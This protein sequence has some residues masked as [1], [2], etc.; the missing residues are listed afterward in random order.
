MS[1][2]YLAWNRHLNI[3]MIDIV[4]MSS[5]DWMNTPHGN[6]SNLAV[7]PS[8]LAP[9]TT[10]MTFFERLGNFLI[11]TSAEFLFNY[12]SREQDEYVQKYFGPGYPSVVEMQK[13]LSLILINYHQSLDGIRAFTPAIVPVG[14]LH[15][16]DRNETLPQVRIII[17]QTHRLRRM[18]IQKSEARQLDKYTFVEPAE[19]AR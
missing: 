2:C 16:I 9:Y 14:G 8:I 13:D 12:Y 11:S 1:V 17:S 10:P 6:P 5:T 18:I 4:T 7:E 19:V 15:V 3:P